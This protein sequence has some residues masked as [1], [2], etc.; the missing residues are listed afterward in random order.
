[1]IIY[2][3]GDSCVVSVDSGSSWQKASPPSL[4]KYSD[5]FAI[6]FAGDIFAATRSGVYR[7]TDS[8][9][10]WKSI[11]VGI[12]NFDIRKVAVLRNGNILAIAY[13]N[14]EPGSGLFQ[15]TDDGESW[16]RVV[17]GKQPNIFCDFAV[18]QKGDV[19]AITQ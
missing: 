17:S 8:A 9:K 19:Y 13:S 4:Q 1:K 6:N 10:T 2:V 12:N 16:S 18:N 3:Q 11:N 5:G 7:S 14:A 15:S